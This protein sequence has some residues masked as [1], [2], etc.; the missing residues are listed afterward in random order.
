MILFQSVLIQ[1][2]ADLMRVSKEMHAEMIEFTK[3]A[4]NYSRVV[5]SIVGL[6]DVD[7]EKAKDFVVNELGVE[8]R[9][10]EYF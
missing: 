4:K 9:E 5:L 6:E 2:Y 10:R 3:K 8:F 7:K 1:Q